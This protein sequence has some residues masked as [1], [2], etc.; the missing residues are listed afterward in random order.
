MIGCNFVNIDT[1]G[2]INDKRMFSDEQG[3]KDALTGIYANM[4]KP[5]LYGCRLS[6][7]FID[8]IAQLYLSLIH[9]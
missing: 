4:A 9:I 3:F 7:G 2:I 6:F 5:E 8:E 1:P